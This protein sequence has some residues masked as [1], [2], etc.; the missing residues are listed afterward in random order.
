MFIYI[1][2]MRHSKRSKRFSKR[3]LRHHV[4]Y[5]A[6]KGIKKP[7]EVSKTHIFTSDGFKKP[8]EV[9]KTHIFTSD[10]FLYIRLENCLSEKNRAK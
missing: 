2:F 4:I 5:V 7:S 1:T 8:S 6:Y 9:S 3:G 10:G